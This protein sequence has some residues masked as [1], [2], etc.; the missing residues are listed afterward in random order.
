MAHELSR[1][2]TTKPAGTSLTTKQYT[3][4]KLDSSSNVVACS[5]TTDVPFGILQNAPGSLQPAL[6]MR[7]GVSRLV[8]GGSIAT[9]TNSVGTD[10]AGKGTVLAAGGAGT[11]AYPVAFV[12]EGVNAADLIGTVDIDCTGAVKRAF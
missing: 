6:V 11:L 8:F 9:G 4:V 1:F 5:A 10:A 2:S 12:E 7:D 3:F